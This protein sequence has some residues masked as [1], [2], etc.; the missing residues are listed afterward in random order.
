MKP[1]IVDGLKAY[2]MVHSGQ[3][4]LL[5]TLRVS[6]HFYW[7]EVFCKCTGSEISIAPSYV[8]SNAEKQAVTMEMVRREFNERPVTVSSW[9]RS[10]ARNAKIPGAAK[11]SMHILG[12]A[13]DFTIDG[14]P[15]SGG[16]LQI[17]RHLDRQPWMR[18]KGMEWTGG[19]WVHVDSRP[20]HVG[21]IKGYRFGA[22]KR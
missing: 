13:T 16:C 12:L 5:L 6:E 8:F 14:F 10:A 20:E 3:L 19:N 4:P 17:Q 1:A 18:K 21:Q 15:G 2:E 7:K 22:P 11:G 9:Y